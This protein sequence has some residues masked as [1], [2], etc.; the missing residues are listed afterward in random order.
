MR[1]LLALWLFAL[2]RVAGAAQ[3]SYLDTNEPAELERAIRE[4]AQDGQ[5][6][7]FTYYAAGHAAQ[8]YQDMA[9]QMCYQLDNL[10]F[11]YIVLAHDAVGCDELLAAADGRLD[12]LPYC[13]VDGMMQK[14]SGYLSGRSN[15]FTLWIR[16][17]HT[18]ALI[19]QAG[20]GVT[21]LD[22][23]TVITRNFLPVLKELE[24][25][26]ALIGLGE[27]PMNGGTWHLRASNGSSAALWVIKEI[28]R[29]ST[30]FNKFKARFGG[31]PG[32][33]MDQD[34][35]GD[36]L[37]VAA[38]PNGSA[39]DFWG[40]YAGTNNKDHAI[41]QHFPQKQP[42]HAF[43]WKNGPPMSSPYLRERCT[44]DA[45]TCKRYERFVATYGLRGAP[46]QYAEIRV[47]LDSEMF[48]ENA[49]P[50]K[51][52]RAPNWLFSMGG[53]LLEGYDDQIAVYHL[54]QLPLYWAN[55]DGSFWNHVSRYAHWLARPGMRTYREQHGRAYVALSPHLVDPAASQADVVYI[56]RL[57]KRLLTYAIGEGAIAVMPRFPCN[58]S[59]IGRSDKSFLG[60]G[61]HRVV[62]D[63]VWCYPSVAGHDS[64]FPGRHYTYP[65]LV[66]AT[67]PVQ[68]LLSLP[69]NKR[70]GAASGELQRAHEDCD[71]FFK[72]LA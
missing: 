36:A 46:L 48:D 10:N 44:W 20:V 49:P 41:Y 4:R 66:P 71:A 32:L 51:V 26:Y 62:D 52:L 16:R 8:M 42:T 47:P 55:K 57:V 24:P 18:A 19:A 23:D 43:E 63:G 3:G 50:E 17:Y 28:E 37:R 1:F 70:R 39:F 11:P 45:D 38:T 31:D 67:A 6:V 33:R 56:K 5:L 68:R 9:L 40:D 22:A 54:L 69:R 12:V 72:E 35:L 27:G 7:L 25:E 58:A 64:C 30:L 60:H 34:E 29:R 14:T 13:V 15:V 65:F 59:W 61:D 53:A 2:Q 21:L